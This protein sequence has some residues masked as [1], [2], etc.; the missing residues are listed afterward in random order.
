MEFDSE[1]VFKFSQEKGGGLLKLATVGPILRKKLTIHD[2]LCVYRKLVEL[3]GHS[4]HDE[5]IPINIF[6]SHYLSMALETYQ[7]VREKKRNHRKKN[8]FQCK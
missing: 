6:V 2:I 8:M 4:L 3:L 1:L 7:S 5:A